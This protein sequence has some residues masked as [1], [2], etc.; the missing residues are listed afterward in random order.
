MKTKWL[1]LFLLSAVLWSCGDDNEEQKADNTDTTFTKEQL[2]S[3]PSF[4]YENQLQSGSVLW[5]KFRDG[6]L[7][8]QQT[9]SGS[10]ESVSKHTMSYTLIEN[11]MYI[12]FVIPTG[13]TIYFQ[14]TVTKSQSDDGTQLLTLKF[15]KEIDTQ[16]SFPGW[17]SKTYKWHPYTF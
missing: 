14:G 12:T 3:A 4:I 13:E 1:F 17:L 5:I 8:T 6:K 15:T 16:S 2:E 10:S 7:M 11:R 9:L